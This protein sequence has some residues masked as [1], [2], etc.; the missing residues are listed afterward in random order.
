MDSIKIVNEE[1]KTLE[2]DRYHTIQKF[3]SLVDL[4]NI[5]YDLHGDRLIT[6]L[7]GYLKSINDLGSQLQALYRTKN[8]LEEREDN[9]NEIK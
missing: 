5:N 4:D 9:K 8:K 2:T 7:E 3:V 1:I 6:K